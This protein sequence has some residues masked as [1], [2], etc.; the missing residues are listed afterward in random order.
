ME[1][2][3]D[4]HVWGAM[5]EHY[6]IHIPKLTNIMLSWMTILSTIRNDLLHEF[7]NKATVHFFATDFDHELLQLVGN[8]IV[9]TL[10]KYWMSYRHLIFIIK[11]F[12]LLMK[13]SAKFDLLFVNIQC[14]IVC[15]LEK[16]NFKLLYLL[17]HV[18]YFNNIAGYVEW[19]FT[20]KSLKVWLKSVLRWLKYRIFSRGL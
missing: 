14:A 7:T 12:E 17:N 15:S 5:L 13:S 10:F 16:V 18:S 8:D 6:R 3:I 9:N 2:P 4:Y 11:T 1:M 19:I 20:Y